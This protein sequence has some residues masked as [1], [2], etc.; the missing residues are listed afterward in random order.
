MSF[1]VIDISFI[2][3][4]IMA[5]DG[6]YMMIGEACS[7]KLQNKKTKV[8]RKTLLW[9]KPKHKLKLKLIKMG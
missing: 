4:Y 9:D 3:E 5:F 8:V 2:D 7:T 1:V 6:L